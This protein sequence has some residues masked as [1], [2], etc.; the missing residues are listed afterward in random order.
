MQEKVSIQLPD[1]NLNV[2]SDTVVVR[3][4]HQPLRVLPRVSPYKVKSL[5]IIVKASA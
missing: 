3:R 2:I 5:Q 4:V 1:N